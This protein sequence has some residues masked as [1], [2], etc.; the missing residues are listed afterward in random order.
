MAKMPSRHP[1]SQR[2]DPTASLPLAGQQHI[3]DSCID[4]EDQ[5]SFRGGILWHNSDRLNIQELP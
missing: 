1:R 2:A 5:F 4:V 3:T